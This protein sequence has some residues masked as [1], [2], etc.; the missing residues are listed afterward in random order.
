[1]YVTCPMGPSAASSASDQPGTRERCPEPPLDTAERL[2]QLR[3]RLKGAFPRTAGLLLRA[4]NLFT[5]AAI[6]LLLLAPV[7]VPET[8]TALPVYLE[9]FTVGIQLGLLLRSRGLSLKAYGPGGAEGHRVKHVLEHNRRNP[10]KPRHSRFRT[11]GDGRRA[12]ESVDQAWRNQG[13]PVR[14]QG[15]RDVYEIDMGRRVGTNGERHIQIVVDQGTSE[16]VTAF[17]FKR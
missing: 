14:S 11:G 6:P 13:R 12:L 16:I 5:R 17:P 8:R 2:A 1:M 7:F 9:V 15:G 3:D 4:L 10:N